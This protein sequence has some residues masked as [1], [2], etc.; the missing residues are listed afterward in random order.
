MTGEEFAKWSAGFFAAFPDTNRW[1]QGLEN[2]AATMA[3]W[4][5][6]LK[7]TSYESANE[8]TDR[9]ARG[10]LEPLP[11]YE[12]E[13]TAAYVRT[14]ARKISFAL[15]TR[16]QHTYDEPRVSCPKCLDTGSVTVW[17]KRSVTFAREHGKAPLGKYV[18]AV[19]CS[20]ERGSGLATEKTEKGYTWRPLP[21]Y[22][23]AFYCRTVSGM[24]SKADEQALLEWIGTG[25]G[26]GRHKEFDDWNEGVEV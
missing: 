22:D 5:R 8:I 18:E 20:C 3:V 14:E 21:R 15:Q 10:D 19:A 25:A 26:S 24:P 2:P 4:S 11:A 23:E 7:E 12:R 13:R 9:M 1:I 17:A 6:V 16:K